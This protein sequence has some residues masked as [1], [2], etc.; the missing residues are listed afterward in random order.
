LLIQ[1]QQIDSLTTQVVQLVV[2]FKNVIGAMPNRSIRI[3]DLRFEEVENEVNPH[4]TGENPELYVLTKQHEGLPLNTLKDYN[5]I[6]NV[7]VDKKMKQISIEQNPQPSKS[8]LDKPYAAWHDLVPFPSGWHPPKFRLFDGIGDARE[9]LAY[10]E[11]MCG[12]TADAPSLLLRQ[13]SGSLTGSAF[14]WYSRLP[15]GSIPDWKTMKELFKSHFMSMK[16]DFSIVELLQV[17]QKRDENID[18]YILR[19]CNSYVW[20]ALEMHPQEVVSMCIHGLQQHWSLEVSCE[21][22]DFSFLSSAVAAT[23]LEFEKSP[24]IMELYKNTG[25][26]DNLKRFNSTTKPNN[27]SNNNKPKVAEANIARASSSMQEG[28]VPMLGTRN[29]VPG[30]RQRPSIQD[31]LKKQ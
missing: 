29:E 30:G 11:A 15:V 5:D 25:I 3:N 13:F 21:P 31:F 6:I 19:F 1:Q 14:Y 10:F 27:N 16:N 24:Q 28:N 20:L 26:P 17:K 23:K 7:L 22:R 9:H 4:K 2:L 12:D 18:D 8:E